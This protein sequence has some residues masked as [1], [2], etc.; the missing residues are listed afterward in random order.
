MK[1]REKW[2][3]LILLDATQFDETWHLCCHK[4]RCRNLNAYPNIYSRACISLLGE[5]SICNRNEDLEKFKTLKW[6]WGIPSSHIKVFLGD[7]SSTYV[8]I[9][10][11]IYSEFTING[12]EKVLVI[13]KNFNGHKLKRACIKKKS[14]KYEMF[15]PHNAKWGIPK[16]ILKAYTIIFNALNYIY[17]FWKWHG[18]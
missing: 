18:V 15:S 1:K 11:R 17:I 14:I 8:L 5:N 7:K 4:H 6:N 12:K 3:I 16:L 13:E 9:E 2:E 10:M